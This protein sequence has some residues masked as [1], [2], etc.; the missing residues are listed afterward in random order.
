VTDADG[1]DDLFQG[2]LPAFGGAY[3][4]RIWTLLDEAVGRGLP[5]TLSVSG[6]VTVSGQH[7]AW[8]NPLL[9]T[10][11]FCLLS[12]TDAVCYH[13]GH[14]ALDSAAA[15]PFHE[16]P[17]FGDDEQLRDD[18]VIRVTDVGFDEELLLD[19]D[20]YLR[21]VLRQ[22][23]FQRRM[24]GTE[25]RALLRRSRSSSARRATARCSSTPYTSG[26]SAR[27]AVRSTPSSST[28]TPR[29]S[30]AVPTTGGARARARRRRSAR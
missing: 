5:M 1:L 14:R 8:L 26:R 19:Q 7:Y 16:V 29:C 24:S 20:R 11:W 10:G 15:H 27:A 2:S 30:R 18:E 9:D 21:A 13:D 25:F 6:P 12:T 23:E 22:P 3:L 4:R 28:C 17:I